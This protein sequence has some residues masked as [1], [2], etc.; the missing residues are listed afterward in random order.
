MKR[1]ITLAVFATILLGL[2]TVPTAAAAQKAVRP[3]PPKNLDLEPVDIDAVSETQITDLPNVT[4][5]QVSNDTDQDVCIA[6]DSV[7]PYDCAS[8][9]ITCDAGANH[10]I[11]KSG[12]TKSWPMPLLA[13]L[14]AKAKGAITTGRF[15]VEERDQ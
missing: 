10:T 1:S 12:A 11:L 7:T 13:V 9:T 14:C 3:A 2:A 5:V 4:E 15:Y 6:V 8:V